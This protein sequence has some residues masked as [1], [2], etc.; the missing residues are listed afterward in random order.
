[1]L[2]IIPQDCSLHDPLRALDWI[3]DFSKKLKRHNSGRTTIISAQTGL[4]RKNFRRDH[5]LSG[6]LFGRE[7]QS[8]ER[9][10]DSYGIRVVHS[11]S[12]KIHGHRFP[13]PILKFF[14]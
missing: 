14:G 10:F 13:L 1:M 4:D 8:A 6:K 9:L 5:D 7:T 12:E 2:I 3:P 11:A